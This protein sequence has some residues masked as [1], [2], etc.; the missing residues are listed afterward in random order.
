VSPADG[1]HLD[2]DQHAVLGKALTAV[3]SPILAIAKED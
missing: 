1:I 2:A 3:V